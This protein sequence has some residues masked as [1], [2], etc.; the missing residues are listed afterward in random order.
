MS[1]F[2]PPT[3]TE[4]KRQQIRRYLEDQLRGIHPGAPLPSVRQMK[5]ACG[6]SQGLL[7]RVLEELKEA[8]QVVASSRRGLFKAPAGPV[9]RSGILDLIYCR[10]EPPIE[11]GYHA[12]LLAA[13]TYQQG[14][15]WEGVRVSYL[16]Y[17]ASEQAFAQIADRADCC[18]CVLI[19]NHRDTL[20]PV[21]FGPRRVPIVHLLPLTPDPPPYSVVV[22]PEEN[23]RLQLEHLW[24]LGHR[25]IA[26]LH[27]QK[28]GAYHPVQA[29]RR[30]SFFRLMLERGFQVPEH[31]VSYATPQEQSVFAVVETI[32]SSVEAPSAAIVAD[33]HLPAFYRAVER[34]GL[35]I[36]QT[37]SVVGTDDLTLAP[38]LSPPATSLRNSR[39]EAARLALTMLQARM[40]QKASPQVVQV[41]SRLVLRSST[42]VC[43]DG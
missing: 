39:T 42:A 23:V 12:E 25:R 14:T 15:F 24:S 9:H 18:G 21:V 37:F 29:G 27:T 3:P 28:Q 22:N 11:R 34:R 20:E 30:E 26:Y 16:G 13:L 41:P 7:M 1:S 8:G 43:R 35:V 31:W 40:E 5:E 6:V 33:G 38:L 19:S 36:G 17:G 2:S 10:A 32:F 4:Q